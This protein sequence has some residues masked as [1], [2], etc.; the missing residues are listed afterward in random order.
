VRAARSE[1]QL[2]QVQLAEL[3][4]VGRMTISRLERGEPVSTEVAIKSLS[5]AGFEIIVVPKFAQ[6]K[7]TP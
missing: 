4:G 6:V 1:R 7:V 3:V 2:D 5:E